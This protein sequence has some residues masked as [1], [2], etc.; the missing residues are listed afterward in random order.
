MLA[1]VASEGRWLAM[2]A[3]LDMQK[4]RYDWLLH[5]R[6]ENAASFVACDGDAIVG[7]V[8]LWPAQAGVLVLGMAVAL[9]RRRRGIG[10]ALVEAALA[11]ARERRGVKC[12]ELAVYPHND[13]ARALYRKC[14]FVEFGRREGAVPRKNGE[15]W[16][17]ILMRRELRRKLPLARFARNRL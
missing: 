10:C 15:A 5:L 1:K 8:S 14:G 6:D 2:E 3:P 7:E 16:D 4:R 9:E 12:V 11:W 17:V 13:A